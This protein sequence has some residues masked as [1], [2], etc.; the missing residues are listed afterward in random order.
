MAA[1]KAGSR[2]RSG[3]ISTGQRRNRGSGRLTHQG[4]EDQDP[5]PGHHWSPSGR[6]QSPDRARRGPAD[7]E[8]HAGPGT[9]GEQGSKGIFPGPL[10]CADTQ[11]SSAQGV[12]ADRD[13][14][15]VGGCLPLSWACGPHPGWP[16]VLSLGAPHPR[17]LSPRASHGSQWPHSD[18]AKMPPPP[19]ALEQPHLYPLPMQ[20]PTGACLLSSLW[21]GKPRKA[22]LHLLHMVAGQGQ[23]L[24]HC[25]CSVNMGGIKDC[26]HNRE[27]DFQRGGSWKETAHTLSSPSLRGIRSNFMF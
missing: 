17:T 22:E 18:P 27:T 1:W 19:T 14:P 25:R 8:R 16:Q 3:A 15:R 20:G 11:G 26:R 6:G 5:K 23:C 13:P 4:Q 10:S 9:T 12:P 24:G 2:K 7:M 21:G